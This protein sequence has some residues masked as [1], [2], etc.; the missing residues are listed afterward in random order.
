MK[1]D[2]FANAIGTV[3]NADTIT[4]D[5]STVPAPTPR[6]A[7]ATTK[8]L[9]LA[10][11]P[12][13][14]TQLAIDEEARQIDHHIRMAEHRDA[15]QLVTAWAV[16]PDDLL[17]NLN[18]HR[19]RIVHFSGHGTA[20]GE[21]MLVDS[22]GQ[23]KPVSATALDA[24]FSTIKDE[25]RLVFLNACYSQI[26]AEAI[27]RNID[28]VVGMNAA[29]GDRAAIVFAAA[30]YRALGFGRSVQASFAQARTSLILE[31][32]PEEATPTLCVRSCASADAILQAEEA[33]RVERAQ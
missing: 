25:I 10:A 19:P 21:L 15:F 13:S 16:R 17:Q 28:F 1:V 20:G 7:F 31:G 5:G 12:R 26:Q 3:M 22:Q 2:L 8:V 9:L 14:T 24:L 30:F 11:N 23:P 32:I 18:R 27:G 6:A 4:I 33:H 29:I